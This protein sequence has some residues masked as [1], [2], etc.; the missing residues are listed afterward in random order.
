MTALCMWSLWPLTVSDNKGGLAI[1]SSKK[2]YGKQDTE[3]EGGIYDQS[4]KEKYM[5]TI[6][7]SLFWYYW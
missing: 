6:D 7:E 1:K 3:D 5:K 4:F 2:L